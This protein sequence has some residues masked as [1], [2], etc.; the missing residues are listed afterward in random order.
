MG[1]GYSLPPQTR[2]SG[3]A[4]ASLITG[5]L[6]CIPFITGICAI[7][8]GLIGIGAT[9]NPAIRGRAMAV[10]GL[11]LGLLSVLGWGL[12]TGSAYYL[13]KNTPIVQEQF[14]ANTFLMDLSSNNVASAKKYTNASVAD[15]DLAAAVAQIKDWGGVQSMA[16]AINGD[17]LESSRNGIVDEN[18]IFP[19]G[20]KLFHFKMSRGD[21][22]TWK[23]DSFTYPS[24]V[25][26]SGMN[27][28]GENP[29]P[30]NPLSR[31]PAQ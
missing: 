3:A 23:I 26:P 4:V 12:F 2:T 20:T 15:T 8:F 22:G 7:I 24:A 14:A 5:I 25:N 29:T 11:I 21:D 10:I 16:P 28:A 30:V 19:S 18:V 17:F 9:R 6:G 31:P 1:G 13:K 27:P